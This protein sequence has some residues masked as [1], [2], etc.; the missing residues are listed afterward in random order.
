MSSKN[1]LQI[2]KYFAFVFMVFAVMTGVTDDYTDANVASVS[3]SSGYTYFLRASN[4]LAQDTNRAKVQI[5]AKRYN[6]FSSYIQHLFA[7]KDVAAALYLSF[8][9]FILAF[10]LF[11]INNQI[12]QNNIWWENVF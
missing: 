7:V 9:I 1:Y 6:V 5:L 8:A 11:Y 4:F 2:N 10:T 12:K 3:Q